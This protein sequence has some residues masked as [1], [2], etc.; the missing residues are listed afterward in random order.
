[1]FGTIIRDSYSK[2]EVG[3][4][5]ECLDDLC[6][7]DDSIGWSSSGIYCFWDLNTKE[8]LYIGLAIDLTIRFMQHNGLTSIDEN[9]CK[10]LYIEEYF[11]NNDKIGFSIFVQS[12]NE[13]TKVYKNRNKFKDIS[14]SDQEAFEL[15]GKKSYDQLKIVE[16]ILIESF[17]EKHNRLP[18]WNK[19]GGSISGQKAA[20]SG[21][22]TIVDLFSNGA[23]SILVSKYSLRELSEDCTALYFEENMHAMR[24]YMLLMGVSFETAKQLYC[25]THQDVFNRLVEEGYFNL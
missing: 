16:G 10:K 13:Q 25:I 19:I 4:I 1:M 20:T 3:L 11:R 24:M 2:D 14:P 18:K 6:C 8:V 7:P 22:Y 21:N 5:V 12:A 17:R 23:S 15:I 9:A